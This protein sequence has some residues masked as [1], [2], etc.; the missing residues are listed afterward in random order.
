MIGE[1]DIECR[2]AAD[3]H[4]AEV[5]HERR[6]AE[7]ERRALAHAGERNRSRAIDRVV[8]RDQERCVAR[9]DRARIERQ[10]DLDLLAR[11]QIARRAG[12]RARERDRPVSR[13]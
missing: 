13:K 10:P 9:R 5:E 2:A 11:R 7:L 8:E 3:G 6:F 4:H 1:R 12:T